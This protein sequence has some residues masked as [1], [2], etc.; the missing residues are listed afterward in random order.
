MM[1]RVARASGMWAELME[2]EETAREKEL[3]E[4]YPKMPRERVLRIV[5]REM[6]EE[7]QDL[8]TWTSGQGF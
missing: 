8:S 4:Q 2:G 1:E 6:V 5:A 3:A 7:E